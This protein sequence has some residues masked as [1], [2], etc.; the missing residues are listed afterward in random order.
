MSRLVDSVYSAVCGGYTEDNDS[1]WG[2]PP[3]PS[4]RGRPDFE[5]QAQGMSPFASGIGT[6]L[7]SQF[8][9]LTSVPSYCALVAPPGKLRWRRR[10][11]QDEIDALCSGLGVGKVR[12]LSVEGRGVSG[13][14]RAMRIEGSAGS[15]RVGGELAIRRLFHNLE[16]GMFVVERSGSDWVFV[17][18]G[19]GHGSGMCQMGAIGRALRGFG[20]RDILGWYYSG[21]KPA[22][23]Y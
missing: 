23:I 10:F 21:A 5:P 22:K 8:V 17:G 14:A 11:R 18:G 2:G 13:R 19:W 7:V 6:A 15:A 4:L 9:R 16:S 3:D 12:S 1:V 20:Y